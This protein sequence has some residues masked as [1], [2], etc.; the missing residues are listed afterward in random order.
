MT[1]TLRSR[2]C[3]PKYCHLKKLNILILCVFLFS[4]PCYAQDAGNDAD[5]AHA[6]HSPFYMTVRGGALIPHPLFNSAFRRSFDGVYA[7]GIS[8]NAQIYKGFTLGLMYKNSEFQVPANK[9]ARLYT[10]E[11]YNTGGIRLGYDYF[12]SK[13]TVF[14]SSISAGHCEMFAYDVSP[15]TAGFDAHPTDR[16]FY[17]EPE[18]AMSFYTEDNF[19]IGFN[20][21]Y[22][23][24]TNQF[25]PYKLALDQHGISYSTGDLRGFTQNV[26]VGFHFVCAFWKRGRKK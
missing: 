6:I 10:K 13:V 25:D 21:A 22:E 3:L 16:G 4:L 19:A 1:R 7:A 12:L 11:Q 9:I 18:L 17:F 23:I 14:S 15:T 20:V 5:I 24:I 8:V 26:S 2:C